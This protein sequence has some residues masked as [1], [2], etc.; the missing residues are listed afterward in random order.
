MAERVRVE[1][2]LCF[3]RASRDREQAAAAVARQRS[4]TS[5][6]RIATALV[7]HGSW[8][9]AGAAPL[10]GGGTSRVAVGVR[11]WR[12]PGLLRD[13]IDIDEI[14]ATVSARRSNRDNRCACTQGVGG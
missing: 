12:V 14:A 2:Q 10:D 3:R 7:V 13:R 8:R 9:E 5:E 6:I 4:R 1:A 11:Q